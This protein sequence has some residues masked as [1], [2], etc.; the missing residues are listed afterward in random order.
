MS[1]GHPPASE[2]SVL[3]HPVVLGDITDFLYS[4]EL[5]VSQSVVDTATGLGAG[6]TGF[7]ISLVD[8]LICVHVQTGY[9]SHPAFTLMGT[10]NLSRG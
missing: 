9:R 7:R 1:Y 2:Y 6:R 8:Y 10:G 4:C 3:G 5:A